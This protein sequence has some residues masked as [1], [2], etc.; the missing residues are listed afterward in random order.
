MRNLRPAALILSFVLASACAVTNGSG[1]GGAGG[2][3]SCA[4]SSGVPTIPTVTQ[5]AVDAGCKD[6]A[7]CDGG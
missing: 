2:M 7:G 5:P 1:A 4:T 3:P 6:D